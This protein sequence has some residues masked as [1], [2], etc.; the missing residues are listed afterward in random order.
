MWKKTRFRL[1][2][3]LILIAALESGS[4]QAFAKGNFSDSQFEKLRISPWSTN[5]SDRFLGVVRSRSISNHFPPIE[6]S[7]NPT[8]HLHQQYTL[9]LPLVVVRSAY[10]NGTVKNCD[11]ELGRDGSWGEY[12]SSDFALVSMLPFPAHSGAW[13]AWLGGGD[14]ENSRISQVVQ[15]QPDKVWLHFYYWIASTDTCGYDFFRVNIGTAEVFALSLCGQTATT[16]WTEASINL[17]YEAGSVLEL[18]F[19]ASTDFNN[20]SSIFV[21]DVY[22]SAEK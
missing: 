6:V 10:C 9:Y 14:N 18:S 5:T 20:P 12:S 17:G 16:A 1:L 21:D 2:S 7:N 3:A 15:V 19:S 8:T 13:G 22:F 4:I 11:F